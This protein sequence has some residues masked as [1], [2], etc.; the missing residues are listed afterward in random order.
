MPHE[1]TQ[2]ELYLIRSFN[3]V[4]SIPNGVR[5]YEVGVPPRSLH[6]QILWERH[7]KVRIMYRSLIRH[8]FDKWE[9]ADMMHVKV[10]AVRLMANKLSLIWELKGLG[11]ELPDALDVLHVQ[12]TS[13]IT[14]E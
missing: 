1:L 8:G 5:R 4:K 13:P 12:H 14:R 3:D 6:A 9:I 11:E 10:S 2:D 7:E